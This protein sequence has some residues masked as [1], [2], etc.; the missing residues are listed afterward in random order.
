M[1]ITATQLETLQAIAT[2]KEGEFSITG[3]CSTWLGGKNVRN[4]TVWALERADLLER[5]REGRGGYYVGRSSG[6][7]RETFT[8]YYRLTDKGRK[9]LKE[10]K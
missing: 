10:G 5:V 2:E 3:G 7:F 1:T 9:V 8:A 4:R 6:R